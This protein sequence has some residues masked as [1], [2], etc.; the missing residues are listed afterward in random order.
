MLDND[1]DIIFLVNYLTGGL[2]FNRE[3]ERQLAD[4]KKNGTTTNGQP[5]EGLVL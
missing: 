5:M 4:Q 3:K 1:T 2:I